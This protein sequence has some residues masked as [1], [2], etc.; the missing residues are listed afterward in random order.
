[1]N[2]TTASVIYK[3]RP[4]EEGKKNVKPGTRV[5]IT[6]DGFIARMEPISTGETM[7]IVEGDV[8]ELASIKVYG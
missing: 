5:R 4:T 1:M 6:I 3:C 8:V 7:V 2:D